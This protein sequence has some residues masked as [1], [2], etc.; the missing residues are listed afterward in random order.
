TGLE[1]ELSRPTPADI[2]ALRDLPG[3]MIVLGVS[4]KM[5]PSL[6]RLA[7]RASDEAGA[8]R[9]IIGVARFSARSTRD[10]LERHGIETAQCDLLDRA[11]VARLPECPNVVYM[12]GQKFGTSSNQPLTWATNVHAAALAAERFAASRIVA[13]STGN[14]YPLSSV[15]GRGPNETDPVGPVGEYA[16][17]SLG[18]ERMFEFFSQKNGTKVAIL[19]LNYA[20]EPR[21][22]VLRDLAD[23]IVRGEPVD[24]AMGHVNVIWQRDANSVALR[25]LTRCASPPFVVNVTGPMQSVHD[26]AE[27]LGLR[28]GVKPRFEGTERET[29]LLS[30]AALCRDVF[31]PAAMTVGAMI[32]RVADWVKAGGGSLG[33]PTH[34]QEH[35]G[36]F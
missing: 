30:D 34:F 13:F 33:K 31:G 22:G 12:V 18:R 29:A 4:G 21:Y 27:R 5:G 16:E 3:D 19:R 8:G 1:E 28:L 25:A 9:R 6:A 36:E 14:V 32:E 23:A 10:L 2:A 11:G 35:E 24:L 17:S 15:A 7:R 26:L 20:I